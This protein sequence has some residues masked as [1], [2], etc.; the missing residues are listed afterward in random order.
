MGQAHQRMD[1]ILQLLVFGPGFRFGAPDDRQNTG[2]INR[3]ILGPAM[4]LQA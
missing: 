1:Q 4:P 2:K 3:S